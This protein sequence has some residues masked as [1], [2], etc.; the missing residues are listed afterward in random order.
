M[1]GTHCKHCSLIP[2]LVSNNNL[3]LL[4]FGYMC[5]G[6]LVHISRL[7]V[8][9]VIIIIKDANYV[10]VICFAEYAFIG[11]Y[12]GFPVYDPCYIITA[13]ILLY[14]SFL[15]HQSPALDLLYHEY[16]LLD[17]TCFISTCSCMLVLT[18]RFSMHV[19][20]SGLLILMCLSMLAT[21]HSYHHSPGSSV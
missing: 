1:Y 15:F 18:I 6:T 9:R 14:H 11:F 13:Y 12:I 5:A 19:Y 4:R 3:A 16:S 10:F 21:W 2:P 7:W 8:R 20:D 17:I